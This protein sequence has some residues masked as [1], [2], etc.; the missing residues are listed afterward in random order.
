M[1][2][3][4]QYSEGQDGTNAWGRGLEVNSFLHPTN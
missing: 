2:L 1:G 3:G 4:Q